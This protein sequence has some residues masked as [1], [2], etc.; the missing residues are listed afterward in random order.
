MKINQLLPFTILLICL[1]LSGRGVYAQTDPLFAKK[2]VFQSLS[3]RWEL[4]SAT[5][6][7]TFLVTPYKPLY[8][9]AGRWS[10]DPNEQ[11]V[12]ENP[13]YNYPFNIPLG[14][15]EAR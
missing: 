11:P 10:S 13:T 15:Y 1:C 14:R 9:T 6:R 12:S 2:A 3:E 7:G 8:V 4:D 5:R